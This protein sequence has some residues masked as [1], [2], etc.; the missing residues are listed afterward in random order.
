MENKID[1]IKKYIEELTEKKEEAYDMGE[2]GEYNVL[3]MV[4]ERLNKIMK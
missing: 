4:I 1:K 3:C 2:H